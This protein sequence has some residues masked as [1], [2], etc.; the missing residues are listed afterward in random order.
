MILV[1]ANILIYAKSVR[2]IHHERASKWLDAQL[3][4]DAPVGLPWPVLLAFIRI[5]TNN[6][7][8]PGAK[9]AAEQWQQALEWLACPPV[10]IPQPTERHAEVLGELLSLPGMGG[11]LVTDAHLAALA[12]EHGATLATCDRDFARFPGLKFFNPLDKL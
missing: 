11:N 9:S 10:W 1:D 6:R 4:G 5:T 3:N 2:S 12:I 8:F 7:A